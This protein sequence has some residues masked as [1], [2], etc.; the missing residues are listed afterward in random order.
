MDHR[1]VRK[2]KIAARHRELIINTY[3]NVEN[4]IELDRHTSMHPVH[5]EMVPCESMALIARLSHAGADIFSLFLLLFQI[6]LHYILYIIF[7][8]YFTSMRFHI[9]APFISISV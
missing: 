1:E 2:R 6:F 9:F 3:L 4:M 7:T 5:T 8:L